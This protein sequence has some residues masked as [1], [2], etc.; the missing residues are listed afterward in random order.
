MPSE[1]QPITATATG[2]DIRI[3]LESGKVSPP[4]GLTVDTD[5]QNLSW[6]APTDADV[7]TAYQLTYMSATDFQ[8]QDT[9]SSSPTALIP[10]LRE[11]RYNV[12]IRTTKNGNFSDT[13]APLLIT[14]ADAT[15]TSVLTNINGFDG[16]AVDD[17][18]LYILNWHDVLRANKKTN[19]SASDATKIATTRS[20]LKSVAVDDKWLYITDENGVARIEKNPSPQNE[21]YTHLVKSLKS[22][23]SIA[24]DD[25][26]LYIVDYLDSKVVK[27]EK[28]G[29]GTVVKEVVTGLTQPARVAVDDKWLYII[30]GKGRVV[31]ASKEGKTTATNAT[32]VV[33]GLTPPA[34][35]VVYGG[36]LYIFD[37]NRMARVWTSE[38]NTSILE[39]NVIS[40]QLNSAMGM[41]TDGNWIYFHAGNTSQ[42]RKLPLGW[43]RAK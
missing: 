40:S 41:A 4:T 16:L 13:S 42:V 26:W 25:K 22:H 12:T 3:I 39:T 34:Y 35:A 29:D 33:T 28:E 7:N 27:V 31:K 23:S 24:V 18:C 6:T 11:D 20:R 10:N 43:V 36:W 17:K 19:T 38:R 37:Q 15:L 1:P 14:R 9:G 2:G 8:K 5:G 32:E 30:E 21:N